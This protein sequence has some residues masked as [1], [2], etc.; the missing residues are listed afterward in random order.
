MSQAKQTS[1]EVIKSLN[2]LTSIRVETVLDKE[3]KLNYLQKYLEKERGMTQIMKRELK[4]K[5]IQTK[6][7]Q[8]KILIEN[9]ELRQEQN[10]NRHKQNP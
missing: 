5:I 4:N 3:K 9:A 2:I 8:Q 10:S 7:L 6:T 1:E